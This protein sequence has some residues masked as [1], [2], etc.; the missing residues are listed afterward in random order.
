MSRRMAVAV[1]IAGVAAAHAALPVAIAGRTRHATTPAPAA[2]RLAGLGCL[3]AGTAG[4]VWSLA[5]HF[6]A[7]KSGYEF[8]LTPE[9]LLRSGPYRFSRN[10]MCVSELTM[11]AGWTLLFAD[12]VLAGAAGLLALAM[13]HSISLEEAALGARFGDTWREYAAQ[14]SRWIAPPV[15]HLYERP[16]R[17][18]VA[19]RRR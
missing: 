14:T 7:A 16:R 17:P 19:Q 18:L 10:P 2:A 4:L 13:R 1:W 11:W 8:T 3:A 5:Q 6:K 12:P 9:Y 15:R